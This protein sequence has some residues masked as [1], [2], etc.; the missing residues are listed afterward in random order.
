MTMTKNTGSDP[1]KK[2]GATDRTVVTNEEVLAQ[3]AAVQAQLKEYQKAAPAAQ[4]GGLTPDDIAK[5][6]AIVAQT[7]KVINPKDIDFEAG[8]DEQDVPVEDYDPIGVRF[9][10]PLVGYLIVDDMRK[11]HRVKLPYNKK[12]VFFTYAATRRTRTG[13]YE[14][15]APL[16]VFRSNS[17]KLTEWLRS[18]TL[19]GIMFYET[20]N[21]AINADATKAIRL[22]SI[23]KSLQQLELHDLFRR[24]KEYGLEMS[25]DAS[26]M[27]GNIAFAMIQRE[28]DGEAEQARASLAETF[29]SSQLLGR[30]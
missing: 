18:H 17:H 22:A 25:E 29:K 20:S 4:T 10:C 11:G 14:Q 12:E 1:E 23:M 6:A 5:I 19:Y 8:I 28:I 24:C 21:E 27:R 3:L 16:S 15:L 9:C 7:Q 2:P 30:G 26:V 13:K